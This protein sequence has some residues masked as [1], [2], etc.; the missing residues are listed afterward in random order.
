MSII[1]KI[2]ATVRGKMLKTVMK[3]YVRFKIYLPAIRIRY[4]DTSILF[5]YNIKYK[6]IIKGNKI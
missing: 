6:K 5:M 3:E 4:I 2:I 1:Y